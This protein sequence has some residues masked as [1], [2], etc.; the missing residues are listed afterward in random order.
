MRSMV[1]YSKAAMERCNESAGSDFAGHGE[2]DYVVASVRDALGHEQVCRLDV[3]VNNSLRMRCIEGI[4]EFYSRLQQP[5]QLYR[6]CANAVLQGYTI[7]KLHH[8]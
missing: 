4:G 1:S 5:F 7:E 3:A 2:T 8:D 6:L